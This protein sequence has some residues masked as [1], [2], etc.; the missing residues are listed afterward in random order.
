[1]FLILDNRI[2]LATVGGPDGP[3]DPPPPRCSS[4]RS[5]G[6]TCRHSPTCAPTTP[7]VP[8]GRRDPF[9]DACA[10]SLARRWAAQR[11]RLSWPRALV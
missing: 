10:A 4:S 5:S 2:D 1:M 11:R 9:P 6:S 3:S 7:A 8:T